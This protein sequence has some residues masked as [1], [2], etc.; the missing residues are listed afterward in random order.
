MNFIKK[1]IKVT[2]KIKKIN[3]VLLKHKRGLYNLLKTE[4][5]CYLKFI[6]SLS[7]I[8]IEKQKNIYLKIKRKAR[9]I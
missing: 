7:I 4:K 3:I 2:N 9:I 1:I 5:Q 8:L 6:E